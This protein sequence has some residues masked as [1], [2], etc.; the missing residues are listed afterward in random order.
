[1]AVYLLPICSV[2]FS[3]LLLIIYFLKKRVDLLENKIFSYMLI[4]SFV[5][6]ILVSMLQTIGIRFFT[7]E[8]VEI[9][10]KIDF[11]LIIIYPALMF[12]Y[13]YLIT[14]DNLNK[15]KIK[16]VFVIVSIV[17]GIMILLCNLNNIEVLTSESGNLSIS[18]FSA[19]FV[20]ISAALYLLASFI[21]V[22]INY[23][24]INK[25]HF[26]L[27]SY[28][29]LAVGILVLYAV[30]PYIIVISIVLTFIN[31]IMFFTI[32]NPDLKLISQL[33][34][35]VS[36]ANKANEAK[37][38]FLS[39][40]SHEIRTPLNAIVG[41][42]QDMMRNDKLH[43]ELAEDANDIVNASKM[44]VE[45][46]GNIMDISK[47]E[48]KKIEIN[49]TK[50]NIRDIFNDIVNMNEYRLY[51]KDINVKID[52]ASDIPYELFGDK[53][54]MKQIM[55]NLISNAYKYTTKGY[56][57]INL[58]CINKNNNSLIIFSVEDSG[59]GIKKEH[60]DKLFTKFERLGAEKNTTIEGTGLGL[61]I[62]KELVAL[63]DGKINV[64]S[65]FGYGSL[66]VIQIPQKISKLVKPI[67]EKIKKETKVIDIS[68]SSVLV[69]D[70]NELNIKVALRALNDSK[71]KIDTASSGEECINKVK[72]NKYDLI[73][74]DIMMP[75]MDGVETLNKLKKINKFNTSVVALTADALADSKKKYLSKGFNG[76]LPKPFTRE[77]IQEVMQK[78]LGD[79]NNS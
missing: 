16:K 69:V 11:S 2:F 56:V 20:Y 59:K 72:K 21:L 1:M 70:D 45:I 67:N 4:I 32:E 57:K 14:A 7:A 33:N 24:K 73:L 47:I 55:S 23:K 22:L 10:N 43:P 19:Y 39:S 74:L 5:D 46:V 41:L 6:S 29:V 44:L 61:A 25:R 75:D 37:S 9:V 36:A 53:Q 8:M 62:T 79:K 35:A 63:L 30:N 26:P 60:V 18:G 12:M 34:L 77:Q 54:H 52:I 28:I 42:T 3:S 51:Q 65:N 27:F 68:G 78:L 15:N 66:F 40:M 76:Y 64:Q 50:Y 58:K 49:N 71:L 38:D 17:T 48:S 13:I 31:Y